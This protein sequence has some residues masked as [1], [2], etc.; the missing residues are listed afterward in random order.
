[1]T[2]MY[3]NYSLWHAEGKLSMIPSTAAVVHDQGMVSFG[4]KKG[5]MRT[6]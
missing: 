6:R 3:D 4:K 2:G 5:P 1:M